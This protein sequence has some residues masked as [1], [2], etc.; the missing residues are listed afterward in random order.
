MIFYL[1]AFWDVEWVPRFMN[2]FSR[3]ENEIEPIIGDIFSVMGFISTCIVLV[4]LYAVGEWVAEKTR[5]LLGKT[6]PDR[7]RKFLETVGA[8]SKEM[9]PEMNQNIVLAEPEAEVIENDEEEWEYDYIKEYI[10]I[11]NLGRY[12][13]LIT[14]SCYA[15]GIPLKIFLPY[16]ILIASTSLPIVVQILLFVFWIG[17]TGALVAYLIRFIPVW[18]KIKS[19]EIKV[20]R[21]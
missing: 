13:K 18:K 7:P 20:V 8:S 12:Y 4:V 11:N 6:N 15:I 2:I 21:E 14:L 5:E 16:Y 9:F 1:T 17:F 10:D 3:Y 19:L